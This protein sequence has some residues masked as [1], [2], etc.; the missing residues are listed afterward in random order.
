MKS[1][2]GARTSCHQHNQG[3]AENTI[4]T[5][6]LT[7]VQQLDAQIWNALLAQQPTPTPFMRHEYLAAMEQSG[8]ATA[9]TGW[10]CRVITVW[11]GGELLAA[12]PLYLKTHSYGEY[13]FDWAWARA[14][15]QHG[16]PYYPKAIAAVP[17]TPVP[18][19]RLMAR[20]QA[21]RQ[22]LV[23]AVQQWCEAEQLSSV[24][25]LF[26][27]A[28]DLSACGAAGWMQRS[29]VQFHW[30]NMAPTLPTACGSLPPEGAQSALGR[31]GGGLVAPTPPTASASLPLT[32]VL[33]RDF[34]DFLASLQQEKR[35]KIRQ[36]R[37]KVHDA[38]V[39]FRTLQGRAI[40]TA[41]WDFFYR[42]Y[43][44]TYL[45][46]GNPPYLTPEFFAAMRETMPENWVMF[47][48]EHEQRPI[49]CSLI[50]VTADCTDISASNINQSNQEQALAA[51]KN[52]VAYGRYWGAL[53]R[54]DSL[55]F[56]ACYYQPIEW[57]IA[58]GYHR[59]EGGAQGEHKMARALLPVETPS[60]HW[61]AH[62]AFADAI[63]RF[64][65]REGEGMADYF[66]A[67]QSHS[68][69]RQQPVQRP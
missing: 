3:M 24:H 2:L 6:V 62:P 57:C 4:I 17:F 52:K 37:R 34:D 46:H 38:G 64:L 19:T 15:Q 11:D 53:E 9:Q 54:V 55:H 32:P 61:V 16:L 13:V 18:G 35:K 29:T 22:A 42:C 45:E 51:I 23:Q 56:E 7:S 66:E 21:L 50:A 68:P 63:A 20:S 10:V 25:L 49:A 44:R 58:N 33:W 43:E 1:K 36:E 39:R 8:S 59:F 41:D 5:R 28:Q 12:C 69:L 67:L 26:G 14:Y 31:P 47:I 27:D 48:A 30:K 60:A 40:S 65:Q